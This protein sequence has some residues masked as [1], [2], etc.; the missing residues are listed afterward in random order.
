MRGEHDRQMTLLRLVWGSSPHARGAHS[1]AVACELACG[2]IPACAGSTATRCA[3]L[4]P[5]WDH[6]R[7]RGEHE[8]QLIG[9]TSFLGSSPHARGAHKVPERIHTV[10]GIIPACAGSTGGSLRA[11][12]PRGD[13]PRMRGEHYPALSR[14]CRETGSSP[15]ARGA[16]YAGTVY[17]D[18]YR[19]I[20]A[21][22]GSTVLRKV[23]R[24]VSEDHPRMRGEH[25][26]RPARLVNILA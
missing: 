25:T 11:Q 5:T 12:K 23:S 3:T 1:A 8:S 6:P 14:M 9:R 17:Y 10:I 24:D 13:H 18:R 4:T 15:H 22:A 21:C 16:Q 2:I 20:P 26:S 7:M 19:I